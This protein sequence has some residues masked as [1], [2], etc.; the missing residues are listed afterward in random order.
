VKDEDAC[1]TGVKADVWLTG[2]RVLRRVRFLALGETCRSEQHNCFHTH[3]VNTVHRRHSNKP[4]TCLVTLTQVIEGHV[5]YVIL[6][7][8]LVVRS[9]SK[10]LLFLDP[11]K[12][13]WQIKWHLEPGTQCF[14]NFAFLIVYYK[15]IV[16]SPEGEFVIAT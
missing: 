5:A 2:E 4:S 11:F 14:P 3:Y 7:T 12:S 1:W 9:W 16:P 10:A 8:E 13:K 6:D 15:Q